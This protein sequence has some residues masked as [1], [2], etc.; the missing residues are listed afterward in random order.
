M[1]M[2]PLYLHVN[3]IVI[4]YAMINSSHVVLQDTL[5]SLLCSGLI[6]ENVLI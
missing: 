3:Q 2:M 6:Q 5:S 4:E 1:W